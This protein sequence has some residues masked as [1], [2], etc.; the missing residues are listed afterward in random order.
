MTCSHSLVSLYTKQKI[1]YQ[2]LLSDPNS[3]I[4]KIPG[5]V[6]TMK[7]CQ[8]HSFDEWVIERYKPGFRQYMLGRGRKS[9]YSNFTKGVDLVMR[10]E[11]I[12]ND[13]QKVLKLADVPLDLSIP[14]FNKTSERS[15]EGYRSYYTKKTRSIVEYV[16]QDELIQYEYSF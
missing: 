2:P 14:V 15:Y 3:W 12:Q 9:L 16:F 8:S 6:E 1:S 4:Y 13:F 5:Y 10:F 11:D 7:F